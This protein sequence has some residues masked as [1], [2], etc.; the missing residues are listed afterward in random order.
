M[1]I[2]R[3]SGVTKRGYTSPVATRRPADVLLLS[4]SIGSGHMRASAAFAKG[5][6][7][8]DP[9]RRCRIVD[10]P[11]EVSPTLEAVLRQAYLDISRL[12]QP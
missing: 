10:F 7:L 5:V 6:G 8:V 1:T 4:C 2:R 3:V 9:G 12:I 11:S